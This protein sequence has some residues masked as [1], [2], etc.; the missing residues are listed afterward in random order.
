VDASQELSRIFVAI[1]R[2]TLVDQFWPRLCNCLDSLTED[3]VWW[4]PNDASNSVG[5]LLLHLDGNLR[6]WIVSGLGGDI[7]TR[8]RDSEFAEQGPIAISELRERLAARIHQVDTIVARLE[9]A[10]L[11]QERNVQVSKDIS[12]MEAVYH[13]VEHFAMHYG[14]ILYITKMLI[15]ADLGFYAYLNKK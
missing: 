14:Q 1:S 13:V 2:R 4:R 7:D 8:D 10:D 6:Q 15:N 11:L 3:Q 5:N 12:G 9:P